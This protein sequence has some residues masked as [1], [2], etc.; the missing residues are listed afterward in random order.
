MVTGM[1]V[2]GQL[3]MRLAAGIQSETRIAVDLS[4]SRLQ[5]ARASGAM[6]AFNPRTDDLHPR[7]QSVTG[8]RG[9]DLVVEAS[10]YPDVLPRVFELCRI[11]GRIILLG[12][13]W[14]RKV[15]IDFMEF[16]LKELVLMGCH[17]PKCPIHPSS[18]FPWTQQY[19]RDQILAMIAD[20][21][22]EVADL[23]SHRLPA[24][25]AKAGY[26]LLRERRDDALGV[27]LEWRKD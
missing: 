26:R 15:E 27:I 8:D 3:V 1:G 5:K 19:N 2:V 23:I 17:Q 21:C 4:D 11:G 24:D 13:I 7:I 22:L 9:L 10:G 20:R 12:S 16:H 6:H 18:L 14:H 25:E